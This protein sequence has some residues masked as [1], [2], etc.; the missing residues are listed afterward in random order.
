MR[1]WD[2]FKV[3]GHRDHGINTGKTALLEAV[4]KHFALMESKPNF[5]MATS[6]EPKR[7]DHYFD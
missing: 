7:K 3:E 1:P 5:R 6:L 2:F 4:N